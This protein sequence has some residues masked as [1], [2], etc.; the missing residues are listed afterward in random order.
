MD[1]VIRRGTERDAEAL[2]E[3]AELTFPLACPPYHTPQNIA[4]HLAEVLSEED[5]ED[6]ASDDDYD[7]FVAVGGGQ[8][9]GFALLDTLACDDE[10][11]EPLLAGLG[12]PTIVVGALAAGLFA[13][14]GAA[15]AADPFGSWLTEEG[16]ATI[17]ISNCGGALCGTIAALKEPS[18]ASAALVSLLKATATEAPRSSLWPFAAA[19][20]PTVATSR[21]GRRTVAA[22]CV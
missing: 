19:A 10:E 14:V 1:V 21:A 6:Y 22:S 7:L 2:A 5:F 9:L 13:F 11:V 15:S 20:S 4:A 12:R 17:R 8:I 16:K 3:L 18:A